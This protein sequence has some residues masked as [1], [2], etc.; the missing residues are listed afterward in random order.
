MTREEFYKIVV[1]LN[2]GGEKAEIYVKNVGLA[3]AAQTA[4]EEC[5]FLLR[6]ETPSTEILREQL[7]HLHKHGIF[8][9]EEVYKKC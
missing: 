3:K 7:T 2:G 6:P 5:I 8:D 9:F 1:E 4:S